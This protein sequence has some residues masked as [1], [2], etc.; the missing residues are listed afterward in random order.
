M[1]LIKNDPKY[2]EQWPRPLVPYKRIYGVDE[3]TRL[4]AAAQR[5]QAVASTCRK[6]RRS[7]WSARRACTSARASRTATVAKGER[8]R[9]RRD[10]YAAFPTREHRTNW[11]GQGAD[12]GLYANSDIHAIR[13]LAMEPAIDPPSPASST[14]TPANGCAS[15]ARSRCA[16]SATGRHEQP[17]DPDGNPDTSFLAKIPADVAWTFQTLDK[18]GMVL[19]MAQTWHQV[20]PGEIR[21]NC[22]GC[23]AH[24]QKPTA[25]QGHRR[26]QAR[27]RGLRPD[28]ADAA[29]DHQEERPVR[30][31]VGRQGRDRPALREG[32]HERRVSPR[33]QA[34]PRAQLRRLPQP[35]SRTSPPATWSS[36][37]AGP[38]GSKSFAS[39]STRSV[40]PSP[41]PACRASRDGSPFIQN[42]HVRLAVPVAQQPADLEAVRPAHRRLPGE[43]AAGHEEQDH[44]TGPGGR[45]FQGQHH[46]A[47]GGRGRHLRRAGRRRSRS[48]R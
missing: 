25:L 7:A 36:I 21:N 27:L 9:D 13:I 33:R 34:D 28:E 26:G 16:S 10:P 32:R 48:R 30:Q 42:P 6:G 46:A 17:L 40:T 5:R 47:A 15:S 8:H 18:D 12:A 39:A 11:D 3:P 22:G 43:T 35:A 45:R 31:E 14:T 29:A 38:H 41:C 1:L 20:R 2:N 37:R 19:N 23:H 4:A 24:S 44:K